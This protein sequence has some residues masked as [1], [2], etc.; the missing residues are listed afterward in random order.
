[1]PVIMTPCP[2]CGSTKQNVGLGS[3][4]CP[5]CRQDREMLIGPKRESDDPLKKFLDP[6]N[7]P[8]K[9]IDDA[10]EGG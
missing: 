6:E 3:T 10:L 5:N 4:I 8:H 9:T 7:E 2:R 1:M